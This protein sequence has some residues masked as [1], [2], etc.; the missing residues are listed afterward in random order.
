MRGSARR[1]VRGGHRRFWRPQNG[2]AAAA[3]DRLG[4]ASRGR[5]TGLVL[6]QARRRRP[7]SW[8]RRAGDQRRRSSTT[9]RAPAPGWIS[10]PVADGYGRRPTWPPIRRCSPSNRSTPPDFAPWPHD[11]GGAGQVEI[12]RRRRRPS[13]AVGRRNWPT[14]PPAIWPAKYSGDAGGIVLRAA[15]G[16]GHRQ[17]SPSSTARITI[18]AGAAAAATAWKMR[19]SPP[20]SGFRGARGR[21]P[22]CIIKKKKKKLNAAASSSRRRQLGVTILPGT[23]G[24]QFDGETATWAGIL[25]TAISRPGDERRCDTGLRATPGS[26]IDPRGRLVAAGSRRARRAAPARDG[27]RERESA[28]RCGAGRARPRR[29]ARCQAGG[30]LNLSFRRY[31]LRGGAGPIWPSVHW[32][33]GSPRRLRRP[34]FAVLAAHVVPLKTPVPVFSRA[35]QAGRTAADLSRLGRSSAATAGH[36]E[37]RGCAPAGAG[38]A[39]SDLLWRNMRV[40]SAGVGDCPSARRRSRRRWA[41]RGMAPA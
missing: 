31:P 13:Q 2:R 11:G 28:R 38:C 23:P 27:F 12:D 40:Y 4:P 25:K 34:R 16:A 26:S 7:P 3:T 37:V 18:S 21:R 41:G 15:G 17:R 29:T 1:R 33:G 5:R 14:R 24:G 20:R 35:V 8:R 19:G 6:A 9:A 32:R 39:D 22:R 10:S 36:C 30:T